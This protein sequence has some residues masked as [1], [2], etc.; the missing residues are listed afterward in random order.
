M[1]RRQGCVVKG[2]QQRLPSAGP[3]PTLRVTFFRVGNRRPSGDRRPDLSDSRHP[4][5]ESAKSATCT[6]NTH[7][8]THNLMMKVSVLTKMTSVVKTNRSAAWRRVPA[9]TFARSAG[10]THTLPSFTPPPPPPKPPLF[11]YSCLSHFRSHG[12]SRWAAHAARP[13]LCPAPCVCKTRSPARCAHAHISA[14]PLALSHA[15]TPA[16]APSHSLMP[17][18][19]LKDTRASMLQHKPPKKD[20]ARAPTHTP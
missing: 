7:T 10:T 18:L 6:G 19:A 4:S 16:L 12:K 1:V 15:L 5:L 20:R 17:S 8:H 2:R 3:R 9:T 11:L 13:A 14:R